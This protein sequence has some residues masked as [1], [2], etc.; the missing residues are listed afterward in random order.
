MLT[1]GIEL[2]KGIPALNEAVYPVLWCSRYF[3]LCTFPFSHS[4]EVSDPSETS[5]FSQQSQL[6]SVYDLTLFFSPPQEFC[7]LIK[8]YLFG[9]NQWDYLN[10]AVCSAVLPDL[11]LLCL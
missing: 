2:E 6:L 10:E 5:G 4:S 9:S 1:I 8:L 3:P 11:A 7:Y